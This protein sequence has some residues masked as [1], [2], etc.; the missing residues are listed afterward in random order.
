MKQ[1]LV[2]IILSHAYKFIDIR[3]P[4]VKW[5]AGVSII[6]TG[7]LFA[8]PIYSEFATYEDEICSL[9][10]CIIAGAFGLIGVSIAGI[11]IVITLFTV[12]QIQMLE[13]LQAGAF[14]DLLYDFKWFALIA[15]LEISVFVAMLFIIKS[16]YPLVSEPAFYLIVF[17]LIYFVFYLAFYGYSLI[18][19]FIKMSKLKQSLSTIP[20]QI[21]STPVQAM[22]LQLNFLVSKLVKGNKDEAK[23]FYTELIEIVEESDIS[24]RDEVA[25]YLKEHHR[26]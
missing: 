23:L 22:E 24:N 14:D 18:G 19:N 25:K 26:F 16:P 8:F 12:E 9:V 5:A 2:K 21:K 1:P 11:A 17:V 20:D 7:L 15:S 6:L 3:Q 4:E 13:E 10:Q